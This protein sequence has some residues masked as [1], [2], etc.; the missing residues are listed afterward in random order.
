MRMLKPIRT[1]LAATVVFAALAYSWGVGNALAQQSNTLELLPEQTLVF[2]RVPSIPDFVTK[3]QETSGGLLFSDERISPLVDELYDAASEEYAERME[4]NV[5]LSMDELLQLPQGEVTFAMVNADD[6]L[7]I[8]MFIDIGDQ[9]ES[10]ETLLESGRK[11]AES[12]GATSDTTTLGDTDVQVL[13]GDEFPI[14]YFIRDNKICI[15]NNEFAASDV[16]ERWDGTTTETRFFD[17]NRKFLTIM[18]RCKTVDDERP[19]LQFFVDP[20]EI[21]RLN[22]KQQ[23]LQGAA[24]VAA[25]KTLGVDGL[26]GVGGTMTMATNNYDSVSHLHVLLANPRQGV[27]EAVAMRSGEITPESWVPRDSTTYITLNWDFDKT[28]SIVESLIDSFRGEGSTQRGL[29]EFEEATE[30]NFFDDILAAQD[31]RLTYVQWIEQPIRLNSQSTLVGVKLTDPGDTQELIEGLLERFDTEG[32][33]SENRYEG[34]T[35]YTTPSEDINEQRRRGRRFNE[36]GEIVEFERDEPMFEFRSPT[37]A[38]GVVGE[39][40]LAS[41]SEECFKAA[42]RASKDEDESLQ[43]DPDFEMIDREI[44]KLVGSN[45]PGAVMYS[46]PAESMRLLLGLANG[47]DLREMLSYG[48][49]EDDSPAIVGR[50]RDALEDNPLPEV[51]DLLEYFAPSGGVM[52]NDETGIHLVLFG[53]HSEASR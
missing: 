10:A 30:V 48:A 18:G 2:V 21:I 15:T 50:L 1:F 53:L 43:G 14:Y 23:G 49:E 9:L 31:G 26:L 34:V 5:G 33:M 39:Y 17:S 12:E 42:I 13:Q 3:Y 27:L 19:Q 22:A 44:T 24:I 40:L 29:E 25:M 41:D 28:F 7:A 6:E 11:F 45:Y 51:E 20:I 32:N 35:Y 36:D 8:V 46:R 37:P 38:F 47:E 52:T 16:I 4:E